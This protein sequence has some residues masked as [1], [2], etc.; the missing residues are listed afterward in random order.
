VAERRHHFDLI[1]RQR[2]FPDLTNIDQNWPEFRCQGTSNF[3]R[4]TDLTPRD[5]TLLD[6]PAAVL[7]A[8]RAAAIVRFFVEP[9]RLFEAIQAKLPLPPLSGRYFSVMFAPGLPML[10]RVASNVEAAIWEK[11]A[12]QIPVRLLMQDNNTRDAIQ[13][14]FAIGAADLTPETR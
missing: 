3:D 4:G 2:A 6:D 13:Q 8:G 12:G 10:F 14:L 5:T 9:Q 7:Q 11:L 1:Q